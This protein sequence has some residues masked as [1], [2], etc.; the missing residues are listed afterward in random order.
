MQLS[1]IIVNYNVKYFLEQCLYSVQKACLGI[2]AEIIDADNNSTD[3]SREYLEPN[4][5]TVNFIWNNENAG[6]AKANNQAL[7][8]AKGAFILFL[9]CRDLPGY[10]P[11]LKYLPG[12]ILGICLKKKIMKWM[13]W[14]V[15]L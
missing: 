11:G 10:F 2:D 4:F 15:H 13:Y 9:N 8:K 7:E 3:G 5:P 12:I 1:V 6:F 14:L